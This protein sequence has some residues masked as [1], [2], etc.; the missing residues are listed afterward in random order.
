MHNN[1]AIQLHR[2]QFDPL[3]IKSGASNTR[4]RAKYRGSDAWQRRWE[5]HLHIK[6]IIIPFDFVLSL[7]SLS[8]HNTRSIQTVKHNPQIPNMQLTLLS[9]FS[10]LNL[11]LLLA[12]P[13]NNDTTP[14]SYEQLTFTFAGGP[15]TY[16]LTFPADG[17]T[18]PTSISHLTPHSL[19]ETTSS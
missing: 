13:I 7:K 17:N 11:P 8:D 3:K 18:Y 10:L 19:T 1:S 15:A 2:L 9:L 12:S 16:T 5:T 14:F 6:I 4:T